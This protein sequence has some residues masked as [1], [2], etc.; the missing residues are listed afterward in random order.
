[1]KFTQSCFIKKNYPKLK[2][3]LKDLGYRYGGK[4]TDSVGHSAL[5]CNTSGEYF[6]IYPSCPARYGSIIDCDINE[7]LFLAIAALNNKNDYMQW[8]VTEEEQNWIN[9]DRY[10]SEGSM[11]LCLAQHRN[12]D[13]IGIVKAHKATVQELLCYFKNKENK[14]K[15]I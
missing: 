14:F 9:L 6:E 15:T 8:F 2:E 4:D 11:E 13:G 3:K 7:E 12:P 10:A 5:Y 1:M